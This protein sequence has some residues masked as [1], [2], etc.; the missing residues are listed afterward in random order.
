METENK[1]TEKIR[2]STIQVQV[3]KLAHIFWRTISKHTVAIKCVH[4]I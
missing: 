1:E 3:C 4:I 2:T